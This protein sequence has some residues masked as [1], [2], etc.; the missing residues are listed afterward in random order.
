MALRSLINLLS[1]FFS[2]T[3]VRVVTQ[4][5]ILDDLCPLRTL[6]N[7]FTCLTRVMKSFNS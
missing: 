6:I 1:S 3:L 7:A 2:K 4:S 5:E